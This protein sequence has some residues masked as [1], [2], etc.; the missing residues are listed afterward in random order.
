MDKLHYLYFIAPLSSIIALIV[1]YVFHKNM[2][3]KDTGTKEMDEIAA[4]VRDGAKAY[5]WQ[6]YKVVTIVFGCTFVLFLILSYLMKLQSG[7]LPFAFLSGGFFSALS[8]Y[9]GMNTATLASVRTTNAART[10]LDGAL[11]IA[12]RSGSVLGLTV[13]GLGLLNISIW[14]YILHHLVG[15]GLAKTTTI[16]LSFGIGASLQALFARVGGGIYTKAADVGADLVGKIEAHLPEDD[17]KNPASIAD[18]VGDNV[19][20]VAG[21]GADLFESYLGSILAA[22]ALGVAAGYGYAGAVLP[23]IIAGAGIILSIIG[24]LTVRTREGAEMEEL[25]K[26]L[27]KGTYLTAGLIVVISYII[28]KFVLPVALGVFGSIIIGL[29]VGIIIGKSTEYYTSY[30]FKPTRK[31]AKSA[32]SGPATVIISGI[33]VGMISTMIPV[34]A[35]TLGILGSYVAAGGMADPSK[36]LFG[37][38]I[39]A[40]GMLSTLGITLAT[41]AYGPIAD[42][43]GGNAE[44]TNLPPE[45]RERTDALDSLGNTTAATGKGFAIGSAALTALALIA[46]YMQEV[47][48]SLMEFKGLTELS[49]GVKIVDA[50][51]KDFMIHF[52]INL[53]NPAV[54]IG[55][56]LGGMLAFVF[57]GMTINAV[58]RAA[59]EMVEE[60]RR[61]FEEMDGILEGETEPDYRSC[62]K[63]S[64]KSALK[65]MI[66]PSLLSV[67]VPV[68]V[69]LILGV[70]GV[71]GLLAG[72]LITAFVLAIFMANSGGAWDN[73]KKYIETGEYGGKGSDAHSASVIG[74]TVGDPFKDTTGPSLNIL[75]KLMSMVSVVVAGL[76]VVYGWLNF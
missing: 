49:N 53:A 63:I 28:V 36:G 27:N 69:G 32:Q 75:I 72:T 14:F 21:M 35:V 47:K 56:F 39:A 66:L 42:N 3:K 44:M 4:H 20:D 45:V 5:L 16:M 55:L 10:S 26:A 68:I 11:K 33:G 70:P 9:F 1:A 29:I 71:M 52:N 59:E 48:M 17:P 19:G 25:I 7:W 12:F 62:I 37:V 65:E 6:Q 30:A 41:D 74:D 57:G 50:A 60:V 31:I 54:L 24:I 73:A 40:V 13:V 58:G 64:T 22:A 15:L 38:A 34:V 61:Q 43:A 76:V 8:G 46:A 23:M 51:L 67:V 2:K 18:N